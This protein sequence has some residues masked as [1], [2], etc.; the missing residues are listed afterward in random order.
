MPGKQVPNTE[1]IKPHQFKPGQSGNPKGRKK[2]SM[3]VKTRIQ[4]WIESSDK[5]KTPDGQEQQVA[6]LDSMILGLI[7]RARGGDAYAFEIL[8]N[9]LEGRVADRVIL[10]GD[11]DAPL[12]NE[13]RSEIDY[14]K[15]STA[16]LKEV[17]AARRH[18]HG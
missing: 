12:I 9:R 16:A 17:A 2:G 13:M 11:Q 7:K 4:Y 10:S 5:I 6:L 8:M 18:K 1:G 15:L 14:S 3:N